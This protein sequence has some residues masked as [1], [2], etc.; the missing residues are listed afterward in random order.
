[1]L[2]LVILGKTLIVLLNATFSKFCIKLWKNLVIFNKKVI[3]QYCLL[4]LT[5]HFVLH[6]NLEVKKKLSKI[7]FFPIVRSIGKFYRF[8]LPYLYSLW[9]YSNLFV[10][11]KYN[12]AFN[13]DLEGVTIMINVNKD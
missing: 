7:D 8:V 1:M 11:L 10:S 12:K 5:R 6:Y 4:Q 3:W 2:V 13:W 9:L